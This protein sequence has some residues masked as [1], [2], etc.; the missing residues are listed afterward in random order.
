MFRFA[1]LW[2]LLALPLPALVWWAWRRRPP[3]RAAALFHPHAEL[4][5]GL[6]TRRPAARRWPW[7]WIAGC[8]LLVTALARPVWIDLLPGEY[9]ARDF[10]IAIDTSGSMRA[11]DFI[12]DGQPADRLAVVKKTVDAL[13]A[14]R[15]GDRAGLIVFGDAAVTVSPVSHDLELVRGLLRDISHG[16]A[17]EKTA[18]GDAVALAVK[19][20]RVRPPAARILLLFTD[21]TNTAGDID[22]ER[23]LALARQYQVRIYAVG[24]GR[25]G[26]VP[27]PGGPKGDMVLA[28]LPMD[29]TLLQR[30]A[31][32]S[33]GHYYRAEA[34]ETLPAIV[35]DI[36]R[37][38]T[39]DV[40]LD[41]IANRRDWYWLPLALGLALLLLAQRRR[42]EVLP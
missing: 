27:F 4:L 24:I 34:S 23:A 11:Q 13:L 41:H 10:M 39:V 2:W 35:A 19:R 17:G 33:G 18:L 30:L 15:R 9:P 26:R 38:E 29:E 6:A 14:A 37:L 25:A 12:L 1:A 16:V 3:R 8:A 5:A 20:L 36:D 22:P 31:T 42:T 40:K 28:E 32:A 21:G 7:L